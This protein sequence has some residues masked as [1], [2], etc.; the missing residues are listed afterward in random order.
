MEGGVVWEGE[1]S[2]V[3]RERRDVPLNVGAGSEVLLK[4]LDVC[5]KKGG[6][7]QRSLNGQLSRACMGNVPEKAMV[8]DGATG[9][10]WLGEGRPGRALAWAEK[11]TGGGKSGGGAVHLQVAGWPVTA[12]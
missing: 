8:K 11:A 5:W 9:D 7:D 2:N 12:A 4:L 1:E 3:G 6:H 10:G